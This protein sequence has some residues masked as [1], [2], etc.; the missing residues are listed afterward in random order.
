MEG[1]FS[2]TSVCKF[3]TYRFDFLQKYL[4]NLYEILEFYFKHLPF[5][6]ATKHQLFLKIYKKDL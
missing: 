5:V 3:M 4:K 1:F 6:A 2:F